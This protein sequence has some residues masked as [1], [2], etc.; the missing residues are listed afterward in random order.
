M[1][2]ID[3]TFLVHL[4]IVDLPI[5]STASQVFARE[6]TAHGTI[7]ALAPQVLAEF[8]HVVTDPRRFQRP[9]SM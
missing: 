8:I 5:H 9:L 6:V 7:V 2:G 3:T 1:I 4:E